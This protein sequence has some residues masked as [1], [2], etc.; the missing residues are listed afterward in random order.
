M[1]AEAAEIA[2]GMGDRR[3]ICYAQAG[4]A[5]VA[6]FEQRWQHADAHPRESRRLGS[7]LGMKIAMV[8]ELFW[9]SGIA[10]ATGEVERAAR[11]ASAAELHSSLLATFAAL[12]D[13][14]S[15]QADIESAKAA[16]D[17]ATWEQASA[18]GRAMTLDEAAGFALSAG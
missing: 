15:Q 12:P 17:P 5:R 3:H 1:V 8:E 14:A 4:L 10:A 18:E 2:T 6:Y 16:C 13:V 9:L 7:G 11:L